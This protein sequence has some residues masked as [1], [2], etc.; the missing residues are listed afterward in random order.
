MR[1]WIII[2]KAN[3]EL[4]ANIVKGKLE[5]YGLSVRLDYESVGRIY[6]FTTDGLGE[7][8]VLVPE[9]ECEEA[10]KILEQEAE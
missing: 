10:K 4:E 8:R 5:S 2:H 9:E 1:K 7:F 3:G 6:G